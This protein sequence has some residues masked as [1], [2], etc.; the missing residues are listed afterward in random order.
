MASVMIRLGLLYRYDVCLVSRDQLPV[1]AKDESHEENERARPL[2]GF[3][4]A[5]SSM[6][7]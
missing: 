3:V 5:F 6:D 1:K 4:V 2:L 7:L